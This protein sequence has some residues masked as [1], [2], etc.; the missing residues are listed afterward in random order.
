MITKLPA[1]RALLGFLALSA[2]ALPGLGGCG[3][4]QPVTAEDRDALASCKADAD[5]VY[6]A[7]NRY[8]LSERDQTGVPN[9]GSALGGNPSAGLP[10]EYEQ[11]QMVDTCLARSGAGAP[12][13]P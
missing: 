10:D 3:L 9:G 13:Q 5:R 8:Q 12:A 7:R 4:Y 1:G 2:P 6:A 11:K